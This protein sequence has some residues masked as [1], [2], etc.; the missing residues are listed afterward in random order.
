MTKPWYQ[1][2]I[3][4]TCIALCFTAFY[5]NAFANSE[6]LQVYQKN[7]HR[8]PERKQQ[9]ADDIHR[10]RHADNLWD[11]LRSQFKLAHHEDNPMVR[12]QINWFMR[13]PE[14]LQ[15][16]T[17]RAAPYLYYI[18]QQARKRHLPAEVVLIP[19]IESAYNPFAYSSAGAAG[20]WQMMPNTASGYGVKQDRWYDGRRDIITSTKAA[21]NH[22]AYLANFF[23]GNWLLAIAAYDT[24]EGNVLAA[25]RKNIRDGYSTSFWSLPV[26]RETRHYVP[27]LLALAAIIA[28]PE[29]YP[30]Q[31]PTVRNAP[32]LAQID[33]G[34]QIDLK[35]A[36]SLAGIKAK[37]LLQLNPGHN[38]STTDPN[39]P[40]KLILPI[41][42]VAKFTE[43]LEKLPLYKRISWSRYKIRR[44]DTLSRI[45][46]RLGVSIAEI[47]KSNP[48]LAENK[49]L[50]P[51]QYL[52]IPRTIPAISKT[53]MESPQPYFASTAS[54]KKKSSLINVLEHVVG[55]YTLQP[56]DTL[57]M[58]RK[59]D[60]LE[61]I[62]HHFKTTLKTLL[63]VNQQSDMTVLRIGDKIIIPTHLSAQQK[64]Y[65]LSP[66]DTIYMV[67]KGDTIDTI[68]QKFRT[69]PSAIRIIN[70]LA[71]NEIREGD[72]LIIPTH[73][74]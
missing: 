24:G 64:N 40:Y 19:I 55:R 53:I 46:K 15:R 33:V 17:A 62:A 58:V 41:E 20:I 8:S 44:G 23:N 38:K 35:H 63:A 31:F 42:N 73:V 60:S 50:K 34:G 48:V 6:G 29:K 57:Y 72:G 25:I 4:N 26:A 16:T 11:E 1:Y 30:I 71:N 68:A 36:A 74:S 67:R 14:Y 13:H 32:Y 5:A 28:N 43:N 69:S 27:R 61:K 59:G 54:V 45:S 66:G 10:Y 3:K 18:A 52:S 65:K 21:L 22:V 7:I 39:G 70:L 47:N 51:G 2:I 49:N 12:Q 37:K 9:L 56:G